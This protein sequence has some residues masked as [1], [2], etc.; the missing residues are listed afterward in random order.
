[1]GQC[2]RSGN[3]DDVIYFGAALDVIVFEDAVIVQQRLSVEVQLDVAT[4]HPVCQVQAMAHGVLE[5]ADGGHAEIVDLV[6]LA[7]GARVRL[8]SQSHIIWNIVFW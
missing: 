1:M 8:E 7:N 2:L 6:D 5:Q 3:H 4:L